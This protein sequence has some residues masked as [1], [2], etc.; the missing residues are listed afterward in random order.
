LL[1]PEIVEEELGTLQVKGIFKISKTEVICGGQVTKGT[2]KSPS[3][4]RVL[5]NK[6]LI[7]D[8]LQVT[9]LQRGPTEV[10]E[11][12]E[13]EMCGLSFKSETRVEVQ[14]DDRIELFTRETKTRTL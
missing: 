7:A 1:A 12:P 9:K 5:R 2:L 10:Q 4:A 13:G 3:L 11:I 8:N 6:E 14:E